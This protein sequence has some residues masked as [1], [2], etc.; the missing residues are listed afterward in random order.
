MKE[1]NYQKEAATLIDAVLNLQEQMCN[2]LTGALKNHTRLIKKEGKNFVDA[3]KQL[4]KIDPK[5]FIKH[6]LSVPFAETE[7]ELALPKNK[8]CRQELHEKMKRARD[9]HNLFII[10]CA[11][12]NGWLKPLSK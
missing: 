10:T 5:Q 6:V 2:L 3:L 4:N 9:A 1:R 12:R 11:L 8:K 7:V